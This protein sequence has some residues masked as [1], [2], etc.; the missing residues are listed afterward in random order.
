MGKLCRIITSGLLLLRTAAHVSSQHPGNLGPGRGAWQHATAED[1]GLSSKK[2]EAAATLLQE[3]A[4][5][6]YCLVVVKDGKMVHESYFVNSSKTRY[7][8]QSLGKTM[9]ATMFG[10]LVQQ[11]LLDLDK[12]LEQYG[13]PR[14]A[15]WNLTGVDY[16]PT[17]TARHL[18][19]QAGG[20]GKVPP[21]T[22]YSYDSDEYIQ[23]LSALM[24]SVAGV[25]PTEWAQNKFA[26][27]MGLEDMFNYDGYIYDIGDDISTGGGQMMSCG[28]IAR[29]GQLLVN[30]GEWLDADDKPFQLIPESYVKQQMA[31]SFPE[32]NSG[33][34]FLTW[35]QFKPPKDSKTHCC[36]P[37]W[38]GHRECSADGRHCAS[39]C[40]ARPNS[41]VEPV[42]CSLNVTGLSQGNEYRARNPA[43]P[44]N[45]YL[46]EGG[47]YVVNSSF[48]DGLPMEI[49]ES[50]PDDLAIMQGENGAYAFVVPSRNL[51][52]V[53]MGM[54]RPQGSNACWKSYDD[55]FGVAYVWA[56]IADSVTPSDSPPLRG[57]PESNIQDHVAERG[58]HAAP[59]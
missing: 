42:T 7:R 6:R 51:T 3:S 11:G 26:K 34:G 18:L 23:Q 47:A 36:A 30:K 44:A 43:D 46:R 49:Q 12:P 4:P 40:E 17:V 57:A 45:F 54:T 22:F 19:S 8:T 38:A 10:T 25:S 39:C 58:P 56:M 20:Y 32:A 5:F 59:K 53:T 31:P 14:N 28:Q 13:V 2:L 33:Y 41:N 1:H 16:W 35:L 52:V 24:R 55:A 50:L 15:S 29:V 27:P 21:G 37:R 9:I 48:G